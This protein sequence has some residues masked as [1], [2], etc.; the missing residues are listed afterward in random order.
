MESKKLTAYLTCEKFTSNIYQALEERYKASLH[1][2]V[3]VVNIEREEQIVLFKYGVIVSWNVSYENLKFFRDFIGNYEIAPLERDMIEEFSYESANDFKIQHDT[4][5]LE[6]DTMLTRIALSHAVAQN[7]KLEVFEKYIQESIEANATIPDQ[8]AK[9]GKIMLSKKEL[10]KKMGEL[11]LVKSSL[12]LHYDLLDTPEFFW[13]YPEYEGYYE[14][15]IKYLDLRAR[16]EVLN[17]KVE[18]IQELFDILGNEQ[19]HKYSSFLEWI[20]ILL[21]AFEIIMNLWD[22]FLA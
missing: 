17:K 6:N 16:V 19:N 22:H 1:K 7:V 9:T 13:E 2:D 15:M 8:L 4:V 21:I 20:I 14:K 12:N 3:I 18:V 5:S 10:S 11:F